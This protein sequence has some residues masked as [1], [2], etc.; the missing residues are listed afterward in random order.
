[1]NIFQVSRD[2]PPVGPETVFHIGSWPIA[3]SSI[4]ILVI[5]V[6]VVILGVVISR[7]FKLRPGKFQ[8]V[9]EILYE[10]MKELV[11]QITASKRHTDMLFPL[12]GSIFIYLGISNV[13]GLIPGLTNIEYGGQPIFRTPTADINTTLGM[14]FAMIV[15]IQFISLKDWGVRGYLGKYFQFK[16][17]YQGF[18][19][20][21]GKG[22]EAVI[23]FFVGLLDII[24]EL[25]KIISLSLRLFGNIYA[26]EVLAVL[27]L[28]AVVYLLPA[29][30]LTVNAFF[31]VI[32]A[33]VF[34]SLVTAYYMIALKP[35]DEKEK[36]NVE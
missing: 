10:K 2:I 35:R 23:E 14:A 28:G 6:M 18:R 29:L 5:V 17:V 22:I 7:K 13:I 1:M 8:S 16:Q 20:G 9:I 34:G 25:A 21:L 3:N 4:M 24:S 15:L 36:Q 27:V 12:I 26:G 19:K 32:Q 31:S 33:M 30:W 11:G